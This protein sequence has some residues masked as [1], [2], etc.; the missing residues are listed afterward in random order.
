MIDSFFNLLD[1]HHKEMSNF[2]MVGSSLE[3][4]TRVYA[5]RVDSLHHDT[6]KMAQ[7]LQRQTA[8]AL[9]RNAD[10]DDDDN[11]DDDSFA[12]QADKENASGNQASQEP[13]EK[14]KRKKK[15]RVVCTVTKNK[16]SINERLDTNPF[17]DPFFAQLNSIVGDINSS[18]RLMQNLLP[19]KDG[20]LLLDMHYAYWNADAPTAIDYNDEDT[21]NEMPLQN[22]LLEE[23]DEAD[24]PHISLKG[25]QITDAPAEDDAA[26]NEADLSAR[27]LNASNSNQAAIVFDPEAEVQSLREDN[28]IIDMGGDGACADFDDP[29]DDFVEQLTQED[30]AAIQSCRGLQRQP[31]IL[32]DMRPVDNKS[33]CLEYS[34]RP[35]DLIS[36]FWAGPSHWKYRRLRS[37]VKQSIIPTEGVQNASENGAVVVQQK[38]QQKKRTVRKKQHEMATLEAV[39]NF[40]T[41]AFIPRDR[42]RP[43]KGIT[44]SK[45]TISIKWN[46]KKLRLPTNLE[47]DRSMFQEFTMAPGLQVTRKE[48]DVEPEIAVDGYNYGNALDKEYCSQ[49]QVSAFCGPK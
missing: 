27:S 24:A 40:E 48:P 37:S 1:K 4:S 33:S 44:L 49:Q 20:E 30:L 12:N 5:L 16:D 46:P 6:L 47:L 19:S 18:N 31:V 14:N 39:L 41:D 21:Y 35:L 36:Q 15:R 22:V 38:Q 7:G 17:T 10:D 43:L 8:K 42:S 32:E 23:F 13:R 29:M 26:D 34:Y 28:V 25:Y 45:K 3:A 9:N 11:Y 2:Q